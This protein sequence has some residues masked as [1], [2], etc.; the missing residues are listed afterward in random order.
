MTLFRTSFSTVDPQ[1]NKYKA[2][3]ALAQAQNEVA[4]RDSGR[5]R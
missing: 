1:S 5:P 2:A 4:M 3:G